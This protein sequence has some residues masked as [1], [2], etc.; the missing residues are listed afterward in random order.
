MVDRERSEQLTV[1]YL[2]DHPPSGV[3]DFVD[4]MQL[5]PKCAAAWEALPDG[6][7]LMFCPGCHQKALCC[8]R[9]KPLPP[10]FRCDICGASFLVG[11]AAVS[12]CRNIGNRA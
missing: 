8:S 2:A 4:D 11:D 6:G 7:T 9:D 3:E 1:K 5:C 10:L 12:C